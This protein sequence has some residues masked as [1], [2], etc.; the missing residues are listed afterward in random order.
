MGPK[1]EGI[2]NKPWTEMV[3]L[4]TTESTKET[5]GKKKATGNLKK[6]YMVTSGETAKGKRIN[7]SDQ[8]SPVHLISKEFPYFSSIF[9]T[10][11]T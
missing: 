5:W 6:Y 10:D 11:V 8:G 2:E 3:P 4:E 9:F 1:L 7:A